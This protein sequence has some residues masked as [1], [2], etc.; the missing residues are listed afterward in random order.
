MA[1]VAYCFMPDHL[2]LL[3]EAVNEGAD[4]ASF[5]HDTKQRSAYLV[6]KKYGKRLWQP[7]YYD[8][9]LRDDEATL[10]VARYVLE[11]PVR[12]GLAKSP[13]DYPFCGSI[14]FSTKQIMEAAAWQP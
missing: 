10:S 8:R 2:H 1:I 14:K 4:A 12:A 7:S 13:L 11:N 6:R 9:I 5:V 3:V